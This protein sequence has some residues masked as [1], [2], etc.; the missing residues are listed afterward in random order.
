MQSINI[1]WIVEPK[2]QEFEFNIRY[3]HLLV[4]CL[5]FY[6]H[7]SAAVFD[8]WLNLL[9]LGSPWCDL[10]GRPL[11]K[12]IRLVAQINNFVAETVNEGQDYNGV[13]VWHIYTLADQVQE[14][15]SRYV[16]RLVLH[17]EWVKAVVRTA[18]GIT[19]GGS[20][21]L[22]DHRLIND[23]TVNSCGFFNEITFSRHAGCRTINTII[24]P[25]WAHDRLP[26]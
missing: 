14:E 10:R 16:E 9:C 1:K 11:I 6:R 2:Y 15:G 22:V 25:D 8:C 4:N 18:T 19:I 21:M 7:F 3:V 23:H 5:G 12:S 17:F 13:L 20:F 24:D 26:Y